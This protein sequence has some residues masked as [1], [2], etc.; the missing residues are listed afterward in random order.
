[1]ITRKVFSQWLLL[2]CSTVLFGQVDGTLDTSFG[3]NGSVLSNYNPH[4]FMPTSSA[5]QS[6]GKIILYGQVRFNDL[7][8]VCGIS[9]HNA[10]GTV[11]TSF[12]INGLVTSDFNSYALYVSK[13]TV[14]T[15]NK[16]V[17][18]GEINYFD[19]VDK[20]KAFIARYNSDGTL[21]NTF[22][23]NGLKI[24]YPENNEIYDSKAIIIQNDN[25]II[26]AGTKGTNL[27]IARVNS[28]GALDTSFGTNGSVSAN[29]APVGALQG[30]SELSIQNDTKII[31]SGYIGGLNG[32]GCILRYNSNGS[33]DNGFGLNGIV[34]VNFNGTGSG[35]IQKIQADGEIVVAGSLNYKFAVTRYNLNGTLD[36]SFGSNGVTITDMNGSNDEPTDILIQADGKIIVVGHSY[37]NNNVGDTFYYNTIA[38]YTTTG[39]LDTSFNSVGYNKTPF[40]DYDFGFTGVLQQTDGKV[41]ATGATQNNITAYAMIARFNSGVLGVDDFDIS[42]FGLYPNPANNIV[43]I[44]LQNT[45][46]NIDSIAI[47]DLLGKSVKKLENVGS[48]NTSFDVSDLEKGIYLVVINTENN[49]KQT[50]KL[51]VE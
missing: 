50:K 44:N 18:T 22:G 29:I 47:N 16:I 48:K 38:R 39:L 13:M 42:N 25:K 11:D 4:Y 21:D 19:M 1:M 15:D 31:C 51:V 23:T 26:I 40:G 2:S 14:Q 20:H 17:I 7:A 37:F 32:G 34:I 46:E 45:N 6:D 33:L 41:L 30:F 49:L 9:R 35:H 28:N 5:L 27:F 43:Y 12:G 10:N 3:L 8:R 24:L 36:S